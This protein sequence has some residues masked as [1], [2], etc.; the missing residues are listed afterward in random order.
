VAQRGCGG[1][2][3]HHANESFVQKA[4][5][6]TRCGIRD[7]EF[8]TRG[9]ASGGKGAWKSQSPRDQGGVTPLIRA[10]AID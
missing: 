3:R 8:R 7:P 6:R 4:K 5:R 1:K 9:T 2:D 10:Y